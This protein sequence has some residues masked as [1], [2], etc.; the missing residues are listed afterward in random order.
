[1]LVGYL[2]LLCTLC[3]AAHVP[4]PQH[5]R[6]SQHQRGH[7]HGPTKE[8][9][10]AT[11]VTSPTTHGEGPHWN[12][13]NQQLYFVD[14]AGKYV[15]RYDPESGKD[16]KVELPNSVTLVIPLRD[17]TD[18]FLITVSHTLAVMTWDGVSETPSSL[19]EI[20]T[21]E[22]D[23]PGNRFNDGKADIR[24]RVW[25]GTMGP[26][27]VVGEV[28]PD[29]ATL[30]LLDTD[31]RTA[32]PK[33]SPVSVSNGIAWDGNVMYYSDTSS[34]VIAAYDYDVDTGN[35]SNRRIVF[36]ITEAGIEG[37]MDGMTIDSEGKLWI[38]LFNGWR[39]IR[40]DPRTGKVE[41][42]LDLPVQR[43]TSVSWGGPDLDQLYVTSSRSG[44]SDEEV[45]QQPLAGCT[46]RVTGLGVKGRAQYNAVRDV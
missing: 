3:G 21:V 26:E 25:A 23:K 33:V 37:V 2:L 1:M 28:T 32:V 24:G 34:Y 20:D 16:Y 4:R 18:K 44:L 31:S 8:G 30:Y 11:T 40:M 5:V 13:E 35:I 36:N 43:P 10:V 38:A 27:P 14:I 7:H 15:H 17:S 9:V 45:A 6:R 22:E 39:V 42:K 41:F 29:Q 19:E 46:W 12:V